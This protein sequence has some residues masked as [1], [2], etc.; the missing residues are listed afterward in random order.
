T[1]LAATERTPLYAT[2]HGYRPLVADGIRIDWILA[3]GVTVRAAAIDTFS[4]DGRF[5]S[6]HLP[7]QA[8]IAL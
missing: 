8:L 2:F 5:A 7:V 3:R 1:W 4:L 6:D